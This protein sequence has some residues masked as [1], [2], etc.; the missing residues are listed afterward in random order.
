MKGFLTGI[1][2][3]LAIGYLTA[4]RSGK[5]T[6]SQLTEAATQQTKGLKEQWNKT[7]ARGKQMV[8][9]VK[10][11][12]GLFKSQPN[13]FADIQSGKLDKYMNEADIARRKLKEGYNDKVA[14]SAEAIKADVTKA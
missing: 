12:S 6:R 4:P 2:T 3:G 5:D 11:N 10:T 9:D 1:V 7:V 8:D 14:E 13:L